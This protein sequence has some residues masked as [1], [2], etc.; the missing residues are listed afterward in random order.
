L[1]KTQLDIDITQLDLGGGFGVPTVRPMSIWDHRLTAN[2]MPP[3][4]VDSAAAARPG[5]FAHGIVSLIR[6]FFPDEKLPTLV[7]EPGRALTSS[8]QC[9]VLKVLA[10][11]RSA[12]GRPKVI[13]DGG[14]NIAMPTGY[15]VHELL[16]VQGAMDAADTNVDFFGPLCHPGDSLFTA[17]RF[18]DVRPD[19]LVAIM[20]A[21][22]YFIPNQ[23]NFSNPRPCAVMVDN[24]RVQVV[25]ERESFADV[26]RLDALGDR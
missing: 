21:G 11:K 10:V 9:L 7:F 19:D 26:I 6:S 8:A 24:D 22:A 13:L 25:R 4:P 14:K 23:M 17:K 1:L 5:D 2:G 20:D 3:G 15:E 12:Q 16:P 18:R